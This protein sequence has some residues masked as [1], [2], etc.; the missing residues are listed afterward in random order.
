MDTAQNSVL[1]LPSDV[2]ESRYVGREEEGGVLS[3]GGGT[4]VRRKEDGVLRG[5][6]AGEE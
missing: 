6:D 4:S 3:G 1:L 5:E 2:V